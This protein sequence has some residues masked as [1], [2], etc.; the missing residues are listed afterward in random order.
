MFSNFYHIITCKR[1]V[2]VIRDAEI[3]HIDLTIVL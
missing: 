2:H 3:Q 1:K